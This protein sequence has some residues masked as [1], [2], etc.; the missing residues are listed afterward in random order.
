MFRRKNRDEDDYYEDDLL[1]DFS[2]SHRGSSSAGTIMAIGSV[3]ALLLVVAMGGVYFA[4]I[5]P[6]LNQAENI[7]AS[8]EKGIAIKFGFTPDITINETVYIMETRPILEL[9]VIQKGLVVDYEFEKTVLFITSRLELEG[10]YLVKAG[11]DL[12]DDVFAIDISDEDPIVVT[13]RLAEP[14]V[15]STELLDYDVERDQG[16]LWSQITGQE[17]EDA[18]NNMNAKARRAALESGILEE[19]QWAIESGIREILQDE[20][21]IIRFEYAR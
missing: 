14:H 5:Q 17:R 20:D 2:S 12:Q 16:A 3:I 6:T 15:L 21:V 8:L 18:V 9:A 13:V 10:N 4:I 19:A 1:D 11:Y 7:A